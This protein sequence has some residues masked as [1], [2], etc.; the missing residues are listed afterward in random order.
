[1]VQGLGVFEVKEH[2]TLEHIHV[3][4]AER[5]IKVAFDH[6][7]WLNS[8]V[9]FPMVIFCGFWMTVMKVILRKMRSNLMDLKM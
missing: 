4:Q 8:R 1:M 6:M 3:L 2:V 9:S 7:V 5:A